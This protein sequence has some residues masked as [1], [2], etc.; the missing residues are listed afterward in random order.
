MVWHG[1]GLVSRPATELTLAWRRPG[2]T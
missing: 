2:S 1:F